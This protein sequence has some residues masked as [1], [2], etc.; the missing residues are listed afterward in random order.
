MVFVS[1]CN[2]INKGRQHNSPKPPWKLWR[3]KQGQPLKVRSW[4]LWR[5]EKQQVTPE[6]VAGA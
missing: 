4:C 2:A 5:K 1:L 3:G 6:G